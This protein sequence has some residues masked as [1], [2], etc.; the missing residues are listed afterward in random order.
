MVTWIPT[1]PPQRAKNSL[2]PC[3]LQV[4]F[5][6]SG[7]CSA[8]KQVL[9]KEFRASPRQAAHFVEWK[10]C[11]QAYGSSLPVAA[12]QDGRSL[13]APPVRQALS[14]VWDPLITTKQ[15]GQQAPRIL[16]YLPPQC[17][18]HNHIPPQW[19]LLHEF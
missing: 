5:S 3:Q 18:N 11:Q 2:S 9:S 8:E 17:W 6:W 13:C 14:H 1:S 15:A 7:D 10:W 19:A 12:A 16:L 4:S